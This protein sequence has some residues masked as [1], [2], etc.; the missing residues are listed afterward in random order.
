MTEATKH[1]DGIVDVKQGRLA[2]M[3]SSSNRIWETPP[4]LF[5]E[6]DD[7]FHFTLDACATE[8][9]A[10][11]K[12]FFTEKDDALTL[13]WPSGVIWCNPPYGRGIGLWLWRGAKATTEHGATV[14]FL[15]PSRTDT[16]WFHTWHGA[17]RVE[18]RFI[19]GRIKFVGADHPAPFPSMLMIFRPVS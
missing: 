13:E 10:K 14:V 17:G 18:V 15:L 16:L 19:K 8:D 12:Q 11:C 3:L 7:E 6:L 4:E 1:D 5:K 9:N 2:P